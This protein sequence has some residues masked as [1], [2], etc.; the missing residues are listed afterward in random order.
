MTLDENCYCNLCGQASLPGNII[1]G[2]SWSHEKNRLGAGVGYRGHK[3]HLC[4]KCLAAA[5]EVDLDELQHGPWARFED[6]V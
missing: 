1:L 4:L 2:F 5:Q 3:Y 6:P